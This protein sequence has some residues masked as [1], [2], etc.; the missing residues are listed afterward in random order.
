MKPTLI[1]R[2]APALLIAT[3]ALP[4]G[5]LA[6]SSPG[7]PAA[8]AATAPSGAP[9]QSSR[10]APRQQADGHMEERVEQRIV[11]LH[12]KLHITS[13]TSNGSSSPR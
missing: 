6:Q 5:A 1:T 7:S 8:G 9:S 3:L 13:K 4:A 11:D 10:P 2:L 12:A